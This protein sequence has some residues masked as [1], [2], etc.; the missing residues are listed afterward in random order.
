MVFVAKEKNVFHL[1]ICKTVKLWVPNENSSV[2][3]RKK[4]PDL[5]KLIIN[6]KYQQMKKRKL[7]IIFCFLT[8]ST[9]PLKRDPRPFIFFFFKTAWETAVNRQKLR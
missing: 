1:N 7:E 8:K 3:Y 2:V 9:D 4:S 5:L 6:Q